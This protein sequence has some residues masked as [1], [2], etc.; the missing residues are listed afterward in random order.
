MRRNEDLARCTVLHLETQNGGKHDV[1]F[2]TG[3]RRSRPRFELAVNH[4]A[5]IFPSDP[6]EVGATVAAVCN[7]LAGL[8]VPL[9]VQP[10]KGTAPPAP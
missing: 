3:F 7:V 10:G 4:T 1:P 8:G 2:I 9:E 5:V 6:M